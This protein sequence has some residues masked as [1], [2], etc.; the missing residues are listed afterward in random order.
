M[1][2]A[3]A[4]YSQ[5]LALAPPSD[6]PVYVWIAPGGFEMGSTDEQVDDAVKACTDAGG[7]CD[8]TSFQ[9]EQPEHAVTLDGYWV[10]RTEVTNEQYKRCVDVEVC[11]PPGNLHWDKPRSARLPVTDVDWD[12]A[13]TYAAWVGGRLPTEAEWE[14]AC[15]S[16]DGRIYPWGD[17]PPSTARLNYN[18][19]INNTTEVG[20]YPS[21]ANGLYDMAGNVWEWTSGQYRPYPYDGT[22]GRENPEGD[23]SRT[24][25]GGAW[26]DF[27]SVVRCANRSGSQPVFGDFGVGF[28]LVSPGS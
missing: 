24:L 4:L 22:D 12:Q 11:G 17:E 16:A 6:T 9:N 2:S 15:R 13:S 27:G 26:R 3:T 18:Q 1:I 20:T 14:N 10:Q 8:V 21:G 5:A 25:R 7:S 23:A 28:R 19:E